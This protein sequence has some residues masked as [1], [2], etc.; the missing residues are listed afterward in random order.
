M[1]VTKSALEVVTR[2]LYERLDIALLHQQTL[3]SLMKDHRLA[4]DPQLPRHFSIPDIKVTIS[5]PLIAGIGTQNSGHL[6]GVIGVIS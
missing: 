3:D 5:K 6:I 1:W 2:L 4:I